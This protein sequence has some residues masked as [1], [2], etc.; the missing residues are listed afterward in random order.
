M[1][2]TMIPKK[3]SKPLI[4]YD[5]LLALIL[6]NLEKKFL[7]YIYIQNPQ[8]VLHSNITTKITDE[9]YQQILLLFLKNCDILI[10]DLIK[11]KITTLQSYKLAPY[12]LFNIIYK[13]LSIH[14][15]NQNIIYVNS[16][17]YESNFYQIEHY[18]FKKYMFFEVLLFNISVLINC[19]KGVYLANSVANIELYYFSSQII[20]NDFILNFSNLVKELSLLI[21]PITIINYKDYSVNEYSINLSQ[22]YTT[23]IKNNILLNYYIDYYILEPKKIYENC[24]IFK[25]IKLNKIYFRNLDILR[26][27]ETSFLLLSQIIIT[28]LLE[29]QDFIIPKIQYTS[30]IICTIPFINMYQLF[31]NKIRPIFKN[32]FLMKKL[33]KS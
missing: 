2:N 10:Y 8:N 9:S 22:R 16:T 27:Y 33:P 5:Q 25:I 6:N 3:N 17:H 19:K 14:L 15:Y 32:I 7:Q 21:S 18:A 23:N 4:L 1:F 30:Y 11:Y 31:K 29:I 12:L 26:N 24:Y 28:Y 13:P 20:L